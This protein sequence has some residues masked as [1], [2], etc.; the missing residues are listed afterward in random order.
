MNH[1][2][3]LIIV[4]AIFTTGC[5]GAASFSSWQEGVERYVQD[6][7]GGDPG[8][9]REVKLPDGRHGF[10]VLGAPVPR[11]STD[12]N[13]VLLNHIPV[14]GQP[15]FIYLVGTVDRQTVKDI[16]LAMLTINNGKYDWR[17]SKNDPQ[18]IKSYHQFQ[19]KLW[20]ARFPNRKTAPPEYT[21]F[22]HAPD[23]FDAKVNTDLITVT[24]RQSGATWE[25]PINGGKGG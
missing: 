16:R 4:L 21:S 7:G 9:L 19:D 6:T 2:L 8:V 22:P 13:A 14:N 23:V 15:R 1:R 12:V 5:G 24:H 17:M 18:A 3:P 10:S 20:R 25:L 11:E